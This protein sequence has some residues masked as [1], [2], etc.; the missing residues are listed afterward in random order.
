MT[1]AKWLNSCMGLRYPAYLCDY[2]LENWL[3]QRDE[4]SVFDL[5]MQRFYA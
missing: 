1:S 5:D 2:E 4:I 3:A